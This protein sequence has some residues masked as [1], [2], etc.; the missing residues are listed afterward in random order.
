MSMLQMLHLISF[1]E[2]YLSGSVRNESR[3]DG[4][5]CARLLL[6][7]GNENRQSLEIM[8]NWS[9]DGGR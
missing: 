1:I 7:H 4:Q 3:N 8:F 2:H 9:K 5:D 6:C